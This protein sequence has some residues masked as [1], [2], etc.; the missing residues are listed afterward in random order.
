[1]TARL[2][3]AIAQAIAEKRIVG[4]VVPVAHNGETVYRRAMGLADREANR[5]M[6]EDPCSGWPLSPSCSRPS[7]R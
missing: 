1:M 5:P 4:A 7:L 3:A 6:R 2:D